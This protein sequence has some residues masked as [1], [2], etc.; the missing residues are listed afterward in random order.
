MTRETPSTN[1]KIPQ[2]IRT[3][4]NSYING[5]VAVPEYGPAYATQ[6]SLN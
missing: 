3:P 2:D 4:G 5:L 1:L 6:K